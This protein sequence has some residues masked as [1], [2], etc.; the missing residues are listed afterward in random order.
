[1][2]R[3]DWPVK[4]RQRNKMWQNMF[5]GLLLMFLPLHSELWHLLLPWESTHGLDTKCKDKHLPFEGDGPFGSKT[6]K[7]LEKLRDRVCCSLDLY[8]VPR[9][10]PP[11]SFFSLLETDLSS[12]FWLIFHLRDVTYIIRLHHLFSLNIKRNNSDLGLNWSNLLFLFRLHWLNGPGFDMRLKGPSLPLFGDRL[13]H[14]I[15]NWRFI[16]LD[17]WVLEIIVK[18]YAI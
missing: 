14:F 16:T 12:V 6:D 4:Y 11:T 9:R 3:E 10:R 2:I 18:G 1:M 5:S 7:L 8:P 13:I 17:K 15:S